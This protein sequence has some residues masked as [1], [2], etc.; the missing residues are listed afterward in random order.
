MKL[1]YVIGAGGLAEREQAQLQEEN[2][3][4]GDIA[5]LS[6]HENMNEGKT[7]EWFQFALREYPSAAYIA[8]GDVDAFVHPVHLARQLSALPSRNLLYGFDCQHN[9]EYKRHVKQTAKVNLVSTKAAHSVFHTS[10][11]FSK[12]WDTVFMCGMFYLFSR[13]TVE[14]AMRSDHLTVNGLEDSTAS[15]WPIQASC[16]LNFTGD[17]YHFFDYP[18]REKSQMPTWGQELGWNRDAVCIHHLKTDVSWEDVNNMLCQ[19]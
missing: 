9:L 17:M 8:K 19:T 3:S 7:Y 14:C 15:K 11:M 4:F 16:P 2:K 12:S 5:M 13:D 10:A 6:I 18:G 1:V